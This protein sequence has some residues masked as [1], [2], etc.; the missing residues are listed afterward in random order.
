MKNYLISGEGYAEDKEELGYIISSLS[1][2]VS[3]M[4][5]D[6]AK[7]GDILVELTDKISEKYGFQLNLAYDYNNIF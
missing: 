5:K 2:F 1:S 4:K 3:R 6:L 7:D